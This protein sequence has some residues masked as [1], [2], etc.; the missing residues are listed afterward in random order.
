MARGSA[1]RSGGRT[2]SNEH[3][4]RSHQLLI[5]DV[6][7]RCTLQGAGAGAGAETFGRLVLVDL[8]G[9]ERLDKSG[10]EGARRKETAAINTSLSALGDVVHALARKDKHVPYRN[11][12]ASP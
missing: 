10:A 4:S 8:A 12:Q 2:N 11:S 3:S 1:A 9:S 5:L 6:H 7:G